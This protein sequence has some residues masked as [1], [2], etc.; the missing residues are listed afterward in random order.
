[1]KKIYSLILA[2]VFSV[3]MAIA[4]DATTTQET[5]EA[6]KSK[7]GVLILPETD[8]WG[9]GVSADPFLTY[10]GNFLNGNNFNSDP[11][12][13]YPSNPADNIA[14]LG[15]LVKD[16]NTFYRVRFNLNIGSNTNKAVISQDLLTPDPLAPAFTEDWRKTKFQSIVIAAGLEKRRGKT[17]LQGVY[18]GEVVLGFTNTVQE[19]QYGNP[20]TIDF[21]V[22]TTFNFGSN[23]LPA[24]ARK[25]EEKFGSN[26]L[27]GARGFIGVEYFFAPKMSIGGEFG[28][29]FGFE[30]QGRAKITSEV[31]DSGTSNVRQIK[32][33]YYNNSGLTSIE[34]GL[35]NL[36]GS[37][38]LLFYF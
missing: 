26:M 9:L 20:I 15:K 6:L 14:L 2:L 18:G 21:N 5:T 13:D 36:N 30:R 16:A 24:G 34:I 28:Y 10:L 37:I 31:W 35:D 19:Y 38:N 23:I 3:S 32:T 7:K 17:R 25:V 4:Q 22:P 1:M 8:E 27:I 29:M 11:D 33:D 12:F